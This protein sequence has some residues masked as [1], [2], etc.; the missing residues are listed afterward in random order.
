MLHGIDI[1]NWDKGL[2]IPESVDFAI[3]KATGGTTFI[4]GCCEG[5]VQQCMRKGILWGYY[6]FAGDYRQ[7]DPEAEASF[8]YE[9][10]Q[11]YTGYGI[12]VLDI[13]SEHIANWGSYAQRFVDKY[14]AITGI[15]PV[16]YCQASSLDSF[17]GYPLVETCGLWVAGYPNGRAYR[18]GDEPPT[19]PY[20]VSPWPFAA[21]WQYSSEGVAQGYDGRLDLD[22]AFMDAHAWELYATGGKGYKDAT[23][24]LPT[25]TTP[26]AKGP[27]WTLENQH[28]KVDI[29]LKGKE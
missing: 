21:L 1:S 19:F 2:E 17:A 16:I 9:H 25:V 13:E 11:G 7:I 27:T 28:V 6:H 24:K 22:V 5:F 20:S 4:D 29:T 18:I 26:A 14:H 12:P 8:F 10:T 3:I 15:W 23:E